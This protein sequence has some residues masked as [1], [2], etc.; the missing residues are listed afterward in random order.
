MSKV[1]ILRGIRQG[2]PISPKLFILCTQMLAY[3]I[4]NHPQIIGV[5]I[6]DN[7]F[8]INQFVDD[9]NLSK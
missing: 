2:C 4:V 6:F 8:R 9:R 5:I 3:L 1:K 7:E